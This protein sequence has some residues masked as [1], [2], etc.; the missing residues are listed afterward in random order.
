MFF[1]HNTRLLVSPAGFPLDH[2]IYHKQSDNLSTDGHV[3]SK[4]VIEQMGKLRTTQQSM[5]LSTSQEKKS[6]S[7]R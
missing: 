3:S 1:S 7:P 2:D 6:E 4:R 5:L